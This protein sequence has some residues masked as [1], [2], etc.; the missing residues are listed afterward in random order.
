MPFLH[1]PFN[2][3]KDVDKIPKNRRQTGSSA[4]KLAAQ[5]LHKHGYKIVET[6]F[7]CRY[8]EIDI[9]ATNK[10]DL[11]FIEVRAKKNLSFGAPEESVTGIKKER[12]V[13]LADYYL[14][15]H[16]DLPMQWRIDVVAIELD[17]KDKATRINIIENA[18]EE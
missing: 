13:S 7:R 10:N 2:K 3:H 4:E 9:I 6:N 18:I 12:L 1:N 17:S 14:Q 16:N 15:K 5:Y 11:V 8:G